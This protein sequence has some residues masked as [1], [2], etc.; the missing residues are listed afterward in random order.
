MD[1]S[2][3]TAQTKDENLWRIAKRRASFKRHLFAYILINLFLW[4]IWAVGAYR[5]GSYEHFWPIYVS[6]GW[7]IGLFFDFFNS[8]MGFKESMEEK[9]YQKLLKK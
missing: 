4:G 9:E 5:H 3:T 6:L 7:G 2:Q 8:Y 1:N